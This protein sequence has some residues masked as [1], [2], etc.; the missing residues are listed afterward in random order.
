M[1]VQRLS[2]AMSASDADAASAGGAAVGASLYE[3]S[4]GLPGALLGSVSGLPLAALT[5]GAGAVPCDAS[6]APCGALAWLTI[7]AAGLGAVGGAALLPFDAG[8]GGPLYALVL[9]GL[10]NIAAAGGALC[11]FSRPPPD[12]RLPVLLNAVVGDGTSYDGFIWLGGAWARTD[13]GA[14]SVLALEVYGGG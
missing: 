4:G 14:Y 7:E 10:A 13:Y 12:A 2:F 6:G 5:R 3:L 11:T 1:S 8:A 9:T